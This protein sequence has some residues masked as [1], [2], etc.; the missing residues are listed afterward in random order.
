M[1]LHNLFIGWLPAGTVD[2]RVFVAKPEFLSYFFCQGTDS[3]LVTAGL[4][5]LIGV[6]AEPMC[7]MCA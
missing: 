4:R 2:C 5:G 6:Q 7:E 1:W 3:R